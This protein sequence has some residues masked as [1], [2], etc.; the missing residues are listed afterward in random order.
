M[1]TS[2]D[3]LDLNAKYSYADYLKWQFEER[4]ELIRGKVFDL[5]TPWTMHQRVSMNLSFRLYSQLNES[6]Y[7][8]YYA[9]FDVR[10][11]LFS[12]K[13]NKE[14][15]WVTDLNHRDVGGDQSFASTN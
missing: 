11:P 1:I 13:K 2:L 3:Q 14:I 12:E 15:S 7:K 6:F 4:V 10:L 9:P 5:P 8:V